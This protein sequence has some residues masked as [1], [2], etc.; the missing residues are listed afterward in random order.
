MRKLSLVI[1]AI[2]L[3]VIVGCSGDKNS[4]GPSSG[5]FVP[6]AIGFT[7]PATDEFS[8]PADLEVEFTNLATGKTYSW[9]FTNSEP[10]IMPGKTF[11]KFDNKVEIPTGPIGEVVNYRFSAKFLGFGDSVTAK[12]PSQD[13]SQLVAINGSP[14]YLGDENGLYFTLKC[15]GEVS[16]S[17]PALTDMK[18]FGT[19]SSVSVSP[20]DQNWFQ[21]G[22]RIS[23]S[24]EELKIS[25]N[26]TQVWQPILVSFDWSSGSALNTFRYSKQVGDD[27]FWYASAN[28]RPW[29]FDRYV[30]VRVVSEYS[31]VSYVAT[32]QVQIFPNGSPWN[33]SVADSA[34]YRT[35]RIFANSGGKG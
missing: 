1:C 14:L 31:G 15:D 16:L 22:S 25:G 18:T 34:G 23:V 11:H 35:F 30:R 17:N 4:V 5:H 8:G 33:S 12:E 10:I 7:T 29:P 24:V 26:G 6:I 13:V 21:S 19:M 27:H 32:N 20:T 9:T 3:M 28:L 2:A